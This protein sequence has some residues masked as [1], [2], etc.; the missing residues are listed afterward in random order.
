MLHFKAIMLHFKAKG[1]EPQLLDK[2]QGT[3]YVK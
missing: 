3:Y 1:V 2:G